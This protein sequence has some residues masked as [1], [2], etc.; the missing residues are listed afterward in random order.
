MCGEIALK[1]IEYFKNVSHDNNKKKNM[2]KS[3]QMLLKFTPHNVNNQIYLQ[4]QIRQYLL[5]FHFLI[6]IIKV[7]YVNMLWFLGRS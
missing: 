6:I 4:L 5:E 2:L 7:K 3:I 1:T